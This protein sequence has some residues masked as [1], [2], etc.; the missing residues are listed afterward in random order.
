MER[1]RQACS[2][3]YRR[4]KDERLELYERCV[5]YL[6]Q[7]DD[8]GDGNGAA[9]ASKVTASSSSSS[10]SPSSP[11]W[12]TRT[13]RKTFTPLVSTFS[14]STSPSGSPSLL[15]QRYEPGTFST[16][17]VHGEMKYDAETGKWQYRRLYVDVP[18]SGTL[19]ARRVWIVKRLGDVQ[20]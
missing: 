2:D 13:L 14:S 3:G 16:G 11:S 4:V 7:G 15:G 19:G 9:A 1:A 18:K 8:G 6:H 17:Q 20:R 5:D 10:S 12:L